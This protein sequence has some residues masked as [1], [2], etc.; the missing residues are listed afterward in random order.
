MKK[1]N[2][3][4]TKAIRSSYD[5]DNGCIA[6]E[7]GT[8][9]CY[10]KTDKYVEVEQSAYY[11]DYRVIVQKPFGDFY[12]TVTVDNERVQLAF[13]NPPVVIVN[14]ASNADYLYGNIVG[15]TRN[16]NRIENITFSRSREGTGWIAPHY[17]AIGRWK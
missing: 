15:V 12:T 8:L 4:N 17:I 5:A 7:D 6:L 3:L 2:F 9:I 16:V 11:N 1:F 14:Q 13:I 10:G